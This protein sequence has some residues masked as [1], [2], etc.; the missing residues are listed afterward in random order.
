MTKET[1]PRSRGLRDLMCRHSI[2]LDNRFALSRQT[3]QARLANRGVRIMAS[4][5]CAN[6]AADLV[7]VSAIGPF[8]KLLIA[9]LGGIPAE[10]PDREVEGSARWRDYAETWRR[11]DVL[12]D[13]T[14]AL[15]INL[16]AAA[17]LDYPLDPAE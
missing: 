12:D 2:S 9:D 7:P 6:E 15:I 14:T 4:A 16:I 1:D 10:R 5:G 3:M 17:R 13:A 11:N 8:I